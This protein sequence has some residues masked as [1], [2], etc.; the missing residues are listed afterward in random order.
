MWVRVRGMRLAL[1][2][3][4]VAFVEHKGAQVMLGLTAPQDVITLT[5]S[6]DRTH[7]G[8]GRAFTKDEL[9]AAAEAE[10]ASLYDDIMAALERANELR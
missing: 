10:A 5:S 4:Y 8:D 7:D 3:K 2:L 9:K 1:N 6:A